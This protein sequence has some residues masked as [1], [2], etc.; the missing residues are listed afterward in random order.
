MD[1]SGWRHDRGAGAGTRAVDSAVHAGAGRARGSNSTF[2][3]DLVFSEPVS[4]S[5]KNLRDHAIRASNGT[6]RA[7]GRVNVGSA[8][9]K[10]TVAPSSRE[11]VTVSVS[12]GWDAC[13]QGDAVCTEDG[14]R[15][16]HSPSVTV[17]GPLAVPVTAE[18]DGVPGEHDG[19]NTF[20]FGLT[21]SEEPRVG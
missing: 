12:G 8:E 20:T 4:A 18:P 19:D 15:L 21:F 10:V 3:G 2:I 14:R 7:A 1:G 6:V 5:Y 16:S 17:E 13:R 11:A 9:W